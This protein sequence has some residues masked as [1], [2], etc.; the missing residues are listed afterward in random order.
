MNIFSHRNII[1]F[2]WDTEK[3]VFGVRLQRMGDG[4]VIIKNSAWVK[5][6][7]RPLAE[8]LSEFK[9][10]I[11]FSE[12]D[13]VIAGGAVETSM[14]FDI[15]LPRMSP[16]DVKKAVK[17]EIPKYLPCDSED[18]VYGCRIFHKASPED[19][20]RIN[21]RIFVTTRKYWNRILG[22]LTASGIKI[23]AFVYPFM[24]L[25]PLLAGFESVGFCG[26]EKNFIFKLEKTGIRKMI[27]SAQNELDPRDA[28][29]HLGIDT[30]NFP[31]EKD[32]IEY[33]PAMLI[34]TYGLS[35]LFR[36]DKYGLI[37]LP[38]ELKPERYRLLRYSAAASFVLFSFLAF[39]FC[40][41]IWWDARGR[42]TRI[43]AELENIQ[44]KTAE[45]KRKAA[46]LEKMDSLIIKK[47]NGAQ[48]GNAEVV[49]CLDR[50][51][52][53]LP[54]DAWLG[55]FALITGNEE[56]VIEITAVCRDNK[57]S[58]FGGADDNEYFKTK[59]LNKR[60]NADGTIN[61]SMN[62]QYLSPETRGKPD[63]KT[64]EN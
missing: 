42:Y 8:A 22:E 3:N 5:S 4:C 60:V 63:E 38:A 12:C 26:I 44:S 19:K 56:N 46:K 18:A 10:R 27:S 24:A 1:A 15:N 59:S 7:G 13:L 16:K 25:D 29:K 14:C 23:D 33:I 17:Y 53:I 52:A 11:D 31:E 40:V 21:V 45:E 2:T 57:K 9:T 34:G 54:M 51:A 41:R 50:I 47:I 62:L 37:S 20:T 39:S 61:I 64:R 35:P 28:V 48:A 49:Q 6:L 55:G 32:I 36:E 58:P 30:K 43:C